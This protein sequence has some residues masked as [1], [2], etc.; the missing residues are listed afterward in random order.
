MAQELSSPCCGAHH[1]HPIQKPAA[2][3]A[4]KTLQSVPGALLSAGIVLFPKCP[5]CWAA[6][7]SMFGS[8]GL[9]NI[10]YMKWLLPVLIGFLLINLYFIFRKVRSR[11]YGPFICSLMGAVIIIACKVLFPEMKYLLMLGI[12]L[13]FS[14]SFWNSF[15]RQK[16]PSQCRPDA[17]ITV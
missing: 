2:A 8:V 1:K 17:S 9:S 16:D 7:M 11:G 10:P 14:G 4:R 15:A 5:M 3:K 12:A 6:Y 13:V